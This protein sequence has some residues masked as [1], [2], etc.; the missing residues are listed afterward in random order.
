MNLLFHADLS[1]NKRQLQTFLETLMKLSNA[2]ADGHGYS[3]LT[4]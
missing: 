4:R 3:I 1:G 2:E